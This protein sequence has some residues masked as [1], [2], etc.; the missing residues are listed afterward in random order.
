M[1]PV[2]DQRF[3][4][5]VGVE[6]LLGMAQERSVEPLLRKIVDCAVDRAQFVYSQVWLIEQGDLRATCKY[7]SE[8]ADQSRCLHLAAAKGRAPS[9]IGNDPHPSKDLNARI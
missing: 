3:D 2:S 5:H 9:S 8:C 7:R 6:L 1:E 4:S